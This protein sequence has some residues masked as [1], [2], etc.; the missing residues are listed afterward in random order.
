MARQY[1]YSNASLMTDFFS[2]EFLE[3]VNIKQDQI[4]EVKYKRGKRVRLMLCRNVF[5]VFLQILIND[6][7]ENNTKF[8]FRGRY[9]FYIYIKKITPGNF[10]R[11]I[12]NGIYKTVNLIDSDFSIY[13]FVFYS[14]YLNLGERF[15]R[16]R[17]NYDTY[18]ELIKKVNNGKRY[19]K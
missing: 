4:S 2:E 6:C 3:K 15:R 19:Y 11:I 1:D 9:W 16:I 17:I 7:I 14:V 8:L 10:N 13:E 5:S 12:N 18:Q